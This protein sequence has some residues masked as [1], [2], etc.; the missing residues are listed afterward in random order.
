MK[1]TA[2]NLGTIKKLVH[3]DTNDV[4]VDLFH[5][6]P[7]IIG[8]ATLKITELDKVRTFSRKRK[9]IEKVYKES[10]QKYQFCFHVDSQI[11]QELDI[12]L[13]QFNIELIVP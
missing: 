13:N 3:P 1:N 7:N 6:K 10:F 11:K 5:M 2:I 4:E 8:E 12:L 9:F